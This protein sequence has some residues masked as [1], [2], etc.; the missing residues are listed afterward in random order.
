[1]WLPQSEAVAWH[2]G[3][4]RFHSRD[5]V[6]KRGNL[7]FVKQFNK[8]FSE[9]DL[10]DLRTPDGWTVLSSVFEERGYDIT[11]TA[12][13]AAA[14]GQ[15]ALL[16]GIE[17]LKVIASGRVRNLLRELCRR[18]GEKRSFVADRK[19]VSFERFQEEW[20][21]DAGR[22]LL[23]WLIER[24]ILFRV[25]LLECPKCKL[26]RWYE[27][28]RIGEIW[29][30]DGCQE[31][32]PIPLDLHKTGWQY[33]VNELYARGHDQGTLTPLLTLNAM[34]IAWGTSS[35][36]GG[37][38][39]Y[40]GIELKA[41]EGADVPFPNK[42]IDLVA[43]RG[44]SLILAECKESTEHLAQEEDS[45]RFARQLGDLVKLADHLGAS[46]LLEASSTTFPEDKSPL[47][48][49]VPTDHLVDLR[50]LDGHDLLDP[51]FILHP[52]SYPPA[53]GERINKPEG[54]EEDYLDWVRRTVAP[55]TA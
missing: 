53:T 54:W 4:P 31:N 16:G 24:R 2:L 48:K 51:N 27:V 36:Y 8:E 41:K 12:K 45:T 1:M 44:E 55:P 52:L 39:F 7:R 18:R 28:D 50:W 46:L 5:N 21:R 42:E 6:S 32:L 40:P 30:C 3:W 38:G 43:M 35:I 47:L 11:P 34:Y 13:S 15:L 23:R 19:T 33:R 10:L 17:H 25:T 26:S 9:S 37:L 29:R 14:L 49:E 22:D 20:G